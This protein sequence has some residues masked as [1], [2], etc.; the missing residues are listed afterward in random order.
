MGMYHIF[1]HKSES[2]AAKTYGESYEIA[3]KQENSEISDDLSDLFG[4]D[5]AG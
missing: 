5:L 1:S 4:I 3:S 2:I